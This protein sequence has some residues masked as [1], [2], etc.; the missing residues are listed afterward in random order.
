MIDCPICLQALSLSEPIGICAPCG[1]PFHPPCF[2]RWRSESKLRPKCPTC[3]TNVDSFAGSVFLGIGTGRTHAG[4]CG[5]CSGGSEA[6]SDSWS[7]SSGAEGWDEG[8]DGLA[9]VSYASCD[10]TDGA[11]AGFE[12]AAEISLE[13]EAEAAGGPPKSPWSARARQ[14]QRT[15]AP[16]ESRTA[17]PSPSPSQWKARARRY[18]RSLRAHRSRTEEIAGQQHKLACRLRATMGREAE[19]RAE[20]DSLRREVRM[21]RKEA[22]AAAKDAARAARRV[23]ELEGA[24]AEGERAL[25]RADARR[26]ELEGTVRR[27]RERQGRDA[28]GTGQGCGGLAGLAAL[29][30][31]AER[32]RLEGQVQELREQVDGYR[33]AMGGWKVAPAAEE[34]AGGASGESGSGSDAGAATDT[35]AGAYDF[36]S[37]DGSEDAGAGT[38][39]M[40]EGKGAEK[41]VPGANSIN[42]K[43]QRGRNNVARISLL[44][45]AKV[46]HVRSKSRGRARSWRGQKLPEDE[47][48]NEEQEEKEVKE[49]RD[50]TDLA[51]VVPPCTGDPLPTP[52]TGR[53][54]P[55]TKSRARR[56]S[57]SQGKP[58]SLAEV[59]NFVPPR[60]QGGAEL[61]SRKRMPQYRGRSRR[62][63]VPVEAPSFASTPTR[64]P[65]RAT[66]SR[67]RLT[68]DVA[69]QMLA[70]PAACVT[71]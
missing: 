39:P 71:P 54:K 33:G 6:L 28:G 18:R 70:A 14:R 55:H 20:R 60:A 56:K 13:A 4:G 42:Q 58:R 36:S 41:K 3:G 43:I 10:W 62:S 5:S 21:G 7:A 51:V 68:P 47:G 53:S 52:P 67:Q 49:E 38:E 65:P 35:G 45:K 29:T 19:L 48:G 59:S 11:E 24:A 16:A 32:R 61:R 15:G 66:R 26:A 37:V 57:Q 22:E 12:T 30:E 8:E 27:M 40:L 25:A 46:E 64:A 17:A 34:A 31:L 9:V 1:H 44:A 23:R 2:E 69:R 63:P 50:A